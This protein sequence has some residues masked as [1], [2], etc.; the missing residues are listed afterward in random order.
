MSPPEQVEAA[1][2]TFPI[3]GASG[4]VI[5]A[6]ISPTKLGGARDRLNQPLFWP[7]AADGQALPFGNDSFD[8]VICQLGLQFFPVPRVGWRNSIASFVAG[9][10]R[11]YA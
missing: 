10:V 7:A 5:G 8:V 9:A 3:V 4:F 2:M 1:L 11:Q 6:D